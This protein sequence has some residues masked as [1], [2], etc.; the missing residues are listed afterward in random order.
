M[1]AVQLYTPT[2]RNP[3]PT[4][5]LAHKLRIKAS[6]VVAY[7]ALSLFIVSVVQAWKLTHLQIPSRSNIS[8]VIIDQSNIQQPSPGP[9]ELAP[10]EPEWEW[11]RNVSIVYTWVVSFYCQPPD[12]PLMVYLEW[13]ST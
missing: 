9:P 12:L 13:L 7:I 6:T 8:Q 1:A 4:A 2:K 3:S 11:A 5:H 10:L